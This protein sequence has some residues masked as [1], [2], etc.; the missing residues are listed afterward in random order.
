ME[1]EGSRLEAE[2]LEAGQRL[3]MRQI[4]IYQ[5]SDIDRP[6]REMRQEPNA[7]LRS[8]LYIL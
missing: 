8:N 2:S 5:Q 6:A 4:L 3:E 1:A 7:D